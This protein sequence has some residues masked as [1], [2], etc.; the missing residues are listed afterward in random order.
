MRM[1]TQ[2]CNSKKLESTYMATARR[3]SDAGHV[4]A[5]AKTRGRK[6]SKQFGVL[7]CRLVQG[8]E[9]RHTYFDPF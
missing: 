6:K 8:P 1:F 2:C 4:T 7:G 9:L 5:Q 3:I